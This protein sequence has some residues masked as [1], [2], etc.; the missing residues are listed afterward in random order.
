M[1]E[2]SQPP[3]TSDDGY[4]YYSVLVD[5]LLLL[6]VR[7]TSLSDHCQYGVGDRMQILFDTGAAGRAKSTISQPWKSRLMLLGNWR[8]D[9]NHP[10]CSLGSQEQS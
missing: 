10:S 6:R 8:R 7:I 1:F 3:R 4:S 2:V 9:P 5:A